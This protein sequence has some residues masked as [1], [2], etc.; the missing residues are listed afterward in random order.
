MPFPLLAFGFAN[1][2]MLGWLAAAAAPLLIHLWSRHRHREAPWAAMQFLLAAMRKNARRL[3][4]QQWLLLAVRTAIIA[5]VVFAAAEPY[6]ERLMAGIGGRPVH[7]IVIIDGSYSMAYRRGETSHFNRAKQTATAM[8]RDS[9]SADTFTVILMSAPCKTVVSRDVVDHAAVIRQIES[10]TQPH[11]SADLAG[12]LSLADA[13]INESSERSTAAHRHEVYFLTDLQ[14]LTW[15]LDHPAANASAA[16]LLDQFA[17]LSK[18]AAVSIV[19]LGDPRPNNLAVTRIDTS[20]PLVTAGRQTDFEVTLHQFGNEPRSDCTVELL[21][22]GVP[23][24]EQTVDVPAGADAAIRFSHRFPSAGQHTVEVRAPGDSLD[25]DNSRWLVVPV[26]SEVRVLCVAGRSGAARYVADALN[27]NPAGDSPIRPVIV[28]E[29]DFVDMDLTK[30]DCV[31]MCNVAQISANDAARLTRYAESGGGVVFFLGDRVDPTSYNSHLRPAEQ[32]L[33]PATIGEVASATQ[34]GLDPLDYRHPIVAPFRGRE[35]AGL[36]TT[37]IT[38]YHRLTLPADRHDVEVAAATA[39][40]NPF[41]VTAPLGR[42]RTILIATD[43]AL[44]SVDHVS[45]EPWTSWPTWP[46]F[47]PIVRELLSY[48]ASGGQQAWQQRVGTPLTGTVAAA[49]NS[50]NAND[51]LLSTSLNLTRPDNR[52]AA[53]SIERTPTGVEWSYSNTDISGLYTLRASQ[54]G[55]PSYF[56]VNV[57][58]TE[59]DLTPINADQLPP[60]LRTIDQMQHDRTGSSAPAIARS[61]WNESLLWPAFAL[62]LVESFLAWR[63]GRGAI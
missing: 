17:L 10:L 22:N 13:A 62:L 31:F 4:L 39:A 33:I 32:S 25:V 1:L 8:V 19:N 46:S 56:A 30:F 26:R 12:A 2:A 34:F 3:Q 57:D 24:S 11:S 60:E 29:G 7:K 14:R 21:V 51:N 20:D 61:R 43:G 36:L 35:R 40:G 58:T 15:Q 9:R 59:S 37:P 28:D 53:L 6:G 45:G 18:Q 49:A 23:V 27:P 42:G 41:I 50:T 47:L 55:E 38:R 44:S 52:P 5:L 54:Q 48:A 63:F 16:P